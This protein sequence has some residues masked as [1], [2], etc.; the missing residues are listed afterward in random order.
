MGKEVETWDSALLTHALRIASVYLDRDDI[1]I[2]CH[3]TSGMLL[4]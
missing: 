2:E 3:I 4:L 1:I